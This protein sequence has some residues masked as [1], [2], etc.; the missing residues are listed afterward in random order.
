MG[1][2][3][4]YTEDEYLYIHRMRTRKPK[5]VTWK[6]IAK[7]F[8]TSISNI[9]NVYNRWKRERNLDDGEYDIDIPSTYDSYKLIRENTTTTETFI[10]TEEELPYNSIE[11][12]GYVSLL[13]HD[14]WIIKYIGLDWRQ[15]YLTEMREFIWNEKRGIILQPRG[16]GKSM[17]AICLFVRHIVENKTPLLVVTASGLVRSC[18]TTVLNIMLS[19]AIRKTYGDIIKRY[20]VSK[21]VI[22]IKPELLEKVVTDPLFCVVGRMSSIIGKHPDFIVLEDILQEKMKTRD[23]QDAIRDWYIN[24]VS[25]M[26]N[27]GTRI[28]VIGTRKGPSD[29]YN[30]L[31]EEIEFDVV[32]KRAV[33]FIKGDFPTK[34]DWTYRRKNYEDGHH[35]MFR[36]KLKQSYIDSI[37]VET[38]DC[39]GWSF[40]RLMKEY[41]FNPIAFSC[42][43]QNNP[44]PS[45]G[46]H[47]HIDQ[48]IEVPPLT[49]NWDTRNV[50]MGIDPSLSGKGDNCA[51]IIATI[52]N[53]E[54]IIFDSYYAPTKWDK[55]LDVID[56]FDT[57]YKF[58]SACMDKT[59]YQQ[60]MHELVLKRGLVYITGVDLKKNKIQRISAL[61]S[62]YSV[63]AIKITSDCPNKEKIKMEY[64]S[65]D[66]KP[67]KGDKFDD[68]LDAISMMRE[69]F[70]Y[71]FRI[72]ELGVVGTA[73]IIQPALSK[74]NQQTAI[75][76]LLG[77]MSNDRVRNI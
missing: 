73:E 31:M 1:R 27:K 52:E 77:G 64:L 10:L 68:A 12:T 29:F 5:E 72:Y 35:R 47:F 58:R 16:H 57:K 33:K 56:Y 15:Q 26:A 40:E 54:M 50:F 53:G 75:G 55:V 63:G 14:D 51:I 74:P 43:M 62:P 2:T 4:T 65:F 22:E 11:P 28:I 42:E 49:Y 37:V 18:I 66:G 39:E 48:W 34:N 30:F 8:N 46:D 25:K 19:P 70:D 13:S 3:R 17:S 23:T 32:H 61:R 69:E 71:A 44:I 36:D 21:G 45:K 59:M 76:S 7:K 9:S 6:E 67:S 41:M 20:S 38:L 24:V 60:M